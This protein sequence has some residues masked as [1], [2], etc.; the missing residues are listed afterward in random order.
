MAY[1]VTNRGH[2][3]QRRRARHDQEH[4]PRPQAAASPPAGPFSDCPVG[5][6][7][8]K[9][10]L[11]AGGDSGIGRA[12]AI[13]F[14]REGADIAIVYLNEHRGAEETR[15]AILRENVRCILVAED[16]ASEARCHRVIKRTIAAFGRLDILVNNAAE[17]QPQPDL[18]RVAREQRE[19][20]LRTNL[21]G[22]FYLTKAAMPHLPAGGAIIN[23]TAVTAWRDSAYLIDD[24]ATTAT[25]VSFTRSLA[26]SL[27]DRGIRA[28]AATPGA[29][30]GAAP[31]RAGFR[32]GSRWEWAPALDEIAPG[33]VSLAEQDG[34]FITGQVL[35]VRAA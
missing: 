13:A 3:G 24:D 34:S 12:V 31:I 8:G 6:L 5:K 17:Q 9:V 10:A 26:D 20:T 4:Q 19:Q 16:T 30:A 27:I 32:S 7:T 28:N 18:M 2:F 14:A 1:A 22:M 23:T 15:R 11:V 25:I 29:A 35:R 21:L 33:Y